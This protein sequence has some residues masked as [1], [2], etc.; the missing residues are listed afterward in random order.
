MSIRA[1]SYNKVKKLLENYPHLAD[2][3]PKCL[4]TFWR[5]EI[6]HDKVKAMSAMELLH[7]IAD[8]KVTSAE[9][10]N[11]AQ[12]LVQENN[13]ELRGA[14]Y[15]QRKGVLQDKAKEEIKIINQVEG[16]VYQPELLENY[17]IKK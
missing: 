17:Q 7:F 11:R 3:K 6:G 16:R 8:E 2:S 13:I 5:D 9:T 10:V 14:K 12:R 4:A 1:V 15:S